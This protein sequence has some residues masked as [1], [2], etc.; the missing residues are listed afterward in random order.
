MAVVTALAV[1]AVVPLVAVVSPVVVVAVSV[2][3]VVTLVSILSVE[4]TDTIATQIQACEKAP[5]EVGKKIRRASGSRSV[6]TPGAKRVGR[7]GACRY[8]FQCTVP[9]L[10][11]LL[12]ICQGGN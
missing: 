2:A 9:P 7:G 1:V 8:C 10:G 11:G 12:H 3:A 4:T 5:S 6:V